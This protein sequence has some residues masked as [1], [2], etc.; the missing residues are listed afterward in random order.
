MEFRV[1][2]RKIKFIDVLCLLEIFSEEKIKLNMSNINSVGTEGYKGFIEFML[3]AESIGNI[4]MDNDFQ[5]IHLF[6]KMVE[7][8]INTIYLK[9]KGK[10]NYSG[11]SLPLS[12]IKTRVLNEN[13]NHVAHEFIIAIDEYSTKI[14]EYL[15]CV[16]R[17]LNN[18]SRKE[19]IDRI[20]DTEYKLLTTDTRI[21]SLAEVGN[22]EA[23]IIGGET[24]NI[25]HMILSDSSFWKKSKVD[26]KLTKEINLVKRTVSTWQ[27]VYN[28]LLGFEN[29]FGL[30]EF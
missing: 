30:T 26:E 11:T 18:G 22:R 21:H 27:K 3:D 20:D 24:K 7:Y 25:K 17:I 2:Y 4:L 5:Y 13:Y 6:G 29:P 1:D 12:T 14:F 9:T 23:S 16:L 10:I 8:L 15:K 19:F 28:F